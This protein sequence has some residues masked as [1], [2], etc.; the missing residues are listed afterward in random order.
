ME[1][2][3]NNRFIKIYCLIFCLCLFPQLS[4]SSDKKDLT[5]YYETRIPLFMNLGWGIHGFFGDP[6]K[7]YFE[8]AK[9]NIMMQKIPV[10]RSIK[11]INHNKK[12]GCMAIGED[13][14]AIG[15]DVHKSIPFYYEKQIVAITRKDNKFFTKKMDLINVLKSKEITLVIKEGFSIGKKLDLLLNKYEPKN[16]HLFESTLAMLQMIYKKRGDYFFLS[17]AEAK[18]LISFSGLDEKKFRFIH[19]KEN[20]PG[21]KYYIA[22]SK[23]VKKEII[24]K[25]NNS[26]INVNKSYQ[27]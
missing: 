27:Y 17:L 21:K 18:A 12:Y 8:E 11:I 25:L 19:F 23:N 4:F 14:N 22:C 2:N 5:F 10:K 26:I 1:N 9:I 16:I 20:L 13:N 6:I 24:E 3:I 7:R 15:S